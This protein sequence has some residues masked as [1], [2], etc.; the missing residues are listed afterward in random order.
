MSNRPWYYALQGQQQGPV[1]ESA[2]RDLVAKG[3]VTA[4]TLV[5]TEGMAGWERADHIPG[6]VSDIADHPAGSVPSSGAA[7]IAEGPL[8]AELELWPFLGRAL[9]FVIGTA[10]VIPAPWTATY[11]YRYVIERIRAPSR[12]ALGFTGQPLDI[13][14]VFIGMGV[15]IY[16]GPSNRPVVELLVMVAQVLLSWLVVRWMVSNIIVDGQ[17]IGRFEGSV[18]TYVGWHVLMIISAITIIGWA[19]VITAWMRWIC[20][21]IQGTRREIIFTAS[22]LEMLWRTVLFAI[23]CVLIIPIPWVLRWY[24]QWYVSQFALVSRASIPASGH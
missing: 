21:N 8:S 24:T 10:F 7:G 1:S 5:W 4:D 3:V 15:L 9:L 22:G 23:G 16:V 20:R 12:S 6:L 11:F 17:P 14:Y 19:W 2:L 18:L 13:W